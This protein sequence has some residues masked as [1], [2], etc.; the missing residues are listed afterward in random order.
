MQR[1]SKQQLRFMAECQRG[2]SIY[3]TAK[4]GVIH[5]IDPFN[6]TFLLQDESS[7]DLHEV[8]VMGKTLFGIFI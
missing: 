1:P 6:R 4:E 8:V 2:H 3:T 5:T 7:V